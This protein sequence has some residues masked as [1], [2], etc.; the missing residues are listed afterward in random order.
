MFNAVHFLNFQLGIMPEET[1]ILQ[2]AEKDADKKG[3]DGDAEPLAPSGERVT[4]SKACVS[5]LR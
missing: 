2:G 1:C 5:T 4:E 3:R